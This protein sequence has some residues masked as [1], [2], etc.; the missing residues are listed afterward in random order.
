VRERERGV[1]PSIRAGTEEHSY[2]DS[3]C[4]SVQ[5]EHETE[6]GRGK[7]N[8]SILHFLQMYS[9]IQTAGPHRPLRVAHSRVQPVAAVH[10]V[11]YFSHTAE[12]S[13]EDIPYTVPSSSTRSGQPKLSNEPHD[14]AE[15]YSID[16]PRRTPNSNARYAGISL[17]FC[18]KEQKKL[19]LRQPD[20]E[21]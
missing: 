18:R 7:R 15:A 21:P 14:C 5:H 16:Y 10:T 17:L 3:A 4:S 19:I 1:S 9:S 8:T 13:T 20:P 2:T 11:L 6:D 12:A